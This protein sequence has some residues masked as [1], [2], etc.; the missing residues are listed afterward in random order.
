MRPPLSVWVQINGCLFSRDNRGGAG[1]CAGWADDPTAFGPGDWADAEVLV[2]SFGHEAILA[3]LSISL[4]L[5]NLSHLLVADCTL[6]KS[7]KP[8]RAV[9]IVAVKSPGTIG[10]N[11]RITA[12]RAN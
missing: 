9:L 12:C 4:D 6:Q 2:V 5:I 1:T 7:S 8:V 3:G 10:A 11:P